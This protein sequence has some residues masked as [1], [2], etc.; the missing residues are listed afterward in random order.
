MQRFFPSLAAIFLGCL[1][2]PA[3]LDA[4]DAVAHYRR[5]VVWGAKNDYDRAI[6]EYDQAIR[7]GFNRAEVYNNRGNVWDRKGE[8]DRA[9]ADSDAAIRLNPGCAVAYVGR[10]LAW[11]QKNEHDKAIADLSEAIRL[12]RNYTDAYHNR[13]IAWAN[14]GEWS[15]AIADCAQALAINPNHRSA[16]NSLAGLYAACPDQNYRN[17]KKAVKNATKAYQLGG[18]RSWA[19]LDVLAAAYAESG[20]FEKAREWQTKAIELMAADK[21]VKDSKKAELR[22]RLE[23]YK[24]GKPYHE[25]PTK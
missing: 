6:A 1:A 14:K 23:L 2:V 17:G 8:K 9:I 10:G 4:Q 19:C 3:N 25:E 21:S 5:G 12:D 16:C 13:G 24:Q 22:S 11:L 15:K 7:L 20:D 18:S